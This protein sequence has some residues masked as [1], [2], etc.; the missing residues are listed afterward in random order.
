MEK[1]IINIIE[2]HKEDINLNNNQ[3]IIKM[4]CTPISKTGKELFEILNYV[5]QENYI[6]TFGSNDY[7]CFKWQAHYSGKDIIEKFI[8][9]YLNNEVELYAVPLSKTNVD[10]KTNS[11][12][13]KKVDK[14]NLYTNS[15]N[16]I[17][18][19]K[20]MYNEELTDTSNKDL[21]VAINSIEK[22]LSN[23][24]EPNYND[25]SVVKQFAKSSSNIASFA[26]DV[27]TILGPFLK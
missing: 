11:V 16:S 9:K 5:V 17:N 21:L 12:D 19:R 23:Y 3:L 8:N 15:I 22:S 25:M 20:F 13:I 26:A 18:A 27:I 24:K 6:L 10:I 2:R 4:K 7:E 14:V 1:D